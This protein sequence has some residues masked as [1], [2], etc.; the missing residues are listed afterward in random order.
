M[1]QKKK[2]ETVSYDSTWTTWGQLLNT[3]LNCLRLITN[4]EDNIRQ[5]DNDNLDGILGRRE[6]G[7]SFGCRPSCNSWGLDSRHSGPD[8]CILWKRKKKHF[9][10]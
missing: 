6:V 8:V 4:D 2:R 7:A 1:K 3:N 5:V 9:F 10:C